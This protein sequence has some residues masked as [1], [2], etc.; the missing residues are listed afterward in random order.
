MKNDSR[1]CSVCDK[2]LLK[3]DRSGFVLVIRCDQCKKLI[4]ERCYLNHHL[5]CHNLIGIV[6]E[7]EV[8]KELNS[9][10]DDIGNIG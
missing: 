3:R 6:I 2:L 9:F 1:F 10:T 5:E 4:H 7:S 8:K